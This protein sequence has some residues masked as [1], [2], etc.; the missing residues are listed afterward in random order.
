MSQIWNFLHK[1]SSNQSENDNVNDGHV[2]Y[3]NHHLQN[4]HSSNSDSTLEGDD[5]HNHNI[6][7]SNSDHET[8][9]S[10]LKRRLSKL[11]N[12]KKQQQQQH[13]QQTTPKKNYKKHDISCLKKDE[14]SQSS[15]DCL[16]D[17]Q[18]DQVNEI[19]SPIIIRSSTTHLPNIDSNVLS[20]NSLSTTSSLIFER[21]VQDQITNCLFS[22]QSSIP[23]HLNFEFFIPQ[24]LDATTE[25][26]TDPNYNEN[27]EVIQS[28]NNSNLSSSLLADSNNPQSSTRP[29]LGSRRMSRSVPISRRQSSCAPLSPIS[30][31]TTTTN[32]ND[33]DYS[34][35]KKLNFCSFADL[36]SD[37]TSSS[38]VLISPT[39]PKNNSTLGMTSNS[40]FQDLRDPFNKDHV[41]TQ[42]PPPLQAQSNPP[43][44]SLSKTTSIKE[45]LLENQSELGK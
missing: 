28:S 38:D 20:P 21:N 18:D 41:F 9:N 34:D 30:T 10:Q 26:L 15:C 5:T 39:S 22:S 1:E 16:I 43:F 19:V 8:F 44:P 14:N 27:V 45:I 23:N 12:H 7:S 17:E 36:L 13:E 25:V 40:T 3:F 24:V 11:T 2:D 6:N 29:G 42:P 35:K 37:E 32:L 31:T 33:V 4:E